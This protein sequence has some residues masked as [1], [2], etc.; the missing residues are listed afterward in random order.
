M[1]VFGRELTMAAAIQLDDVTKLSGRH[2]GVLDL[3]LAVRT[4]ECF[5]FLAPNS[6][7]K[8]TTIRMLLDLIRPTQG[9]VSVLGL[10]SRRDSV[11]I[12]RRRGY[13]PGGV[14]R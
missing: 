4:G 2:R 5:G 1:I 10:D 7:G 3:T 12:R 9:R 14:P 8:S 11:E 6:A 13:L